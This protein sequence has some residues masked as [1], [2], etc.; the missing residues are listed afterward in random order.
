[1]RAIA[2]KNTL[3]TVHCSSAG[4]TVSQCRPILLPLS[5]LHISDVGILNPFHQ[6]RIICLTFRKSRLNHLR[7]VFKTNCDETCARVIPLIGLTGLIRGEPLYTL[8]SLLYRLIQ[9]C[10][11]STSDTY[12]AN[13]YEFCR[14]PY[15]GGGGYRTTFVTNFTSIPPS[16]LIFRLFHLLSFFFS[17][18]F[19]T[20]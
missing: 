6:L 4:S 13:L 9:S 5:N 11:H 20:S 2:L 15:S 8:F 10:Q 12:Q 17:Y 1:M 16:Y 14:E 3:S 19:S 18:C 7:L